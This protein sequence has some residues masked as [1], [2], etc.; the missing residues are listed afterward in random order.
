MRRITSRP[1]FKD[2]PP[3]GKQYPKLILTIREEQF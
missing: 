2:A 1:R 3:L